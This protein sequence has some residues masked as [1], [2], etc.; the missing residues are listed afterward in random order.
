MFAEYKYFGIPSCEKKF[1]FFPAMDGGFQK[2]AF[3]Y[4]MSFVVEINFIILC[5]VYKNL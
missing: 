4:V 2:C 1:D 3:S 5:G